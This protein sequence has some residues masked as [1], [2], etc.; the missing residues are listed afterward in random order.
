MH[1]NLLNFTATL[2]VPAPF[3]QGTDGARITAAVENLSAM[4]PGRGLKAP[5]LR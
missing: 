3:W 4:P 1:G 2:F 5:R